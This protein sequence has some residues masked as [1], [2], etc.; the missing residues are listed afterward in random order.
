M[1]GVAGARKKCDYVV[2]E[3][4]FDACVSHH[5]DTLAAT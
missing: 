2:D 3:L 5:S 1:V 4:G